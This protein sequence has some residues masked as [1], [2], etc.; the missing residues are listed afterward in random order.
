MNRPHHHQPQHGNH[1][2]VIKQQYDSYN[3]WEF[4]NKWEAGL[5]GCKPAS[6][7]CFACF[8]PCCMGCKL[9]SRLGET[10][11]IGCCPCT[12]CY[13]RTK[14][15]TARRIDGFCCGDLCS[16]WACGPCAA[17]QLA[18]ELDH[19]G[20]WEQEAAKKNKPVRNERYN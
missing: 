6:R 16:T 12:L 17:T 18:F 11:I 1:P 10:A 8:C 9:A 5:C 19:Q 20:L 15:R 7:C 4:E 13:L 2:A 3:V 14:L